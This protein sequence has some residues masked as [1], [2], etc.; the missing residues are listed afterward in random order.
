[1]IINAQVIHEKDFFGGPYVPEFIFNKYGPLKLATW[2]SLFLECSCIFL[3]WSRNKY[4]KYGTVYSMIALHLGIESTMNMHVFEILSIIGWC[5]FLIQPDISHRDYKSMTAKTNTDLNRKTMTRY[6]LDIIQ[7][8]WVVN[9]FLLAITTILILD[10]FPLYEIQDV[11]NGVI[12]V[13]LSSLLAKITSPSQ[14]SVVSGLVYAINHIETKLLYLNEL[15]R[16]YLFP[17]VTKY[18]YP[19]GLYQAVWTLYSGA[20]DMSCIFTTNITAYTIMP[21]S[22]SSNHQLN[23]YSYVSPD[24]GTMTWYEKKRYQR[25]MTMQEK[26][27]DYMYRD[28]YVRY[29]TNNIFNDVLSNEEAN[30]TNLHLA[31]ATL[32]VQCEHPPPAPDIDDWFNWSG[33]FYADAKQD[34]LVQREP[35]LLYTTN[36]CNDLNVELC[37]QYNNEGL[38]YIAQSHHSVRHRFDATNIDVLKEKEALVYNITQTCR[39]SCNFCPEDGYDTNDLSIGTRIS[40]YWPIPTW[41]DTDQ[42]YYYDEKSLYYPGTIVQVR[43]HPLKQ[44]RIKYDESGYNDEWFD[45]MTL[46]DRGYHFVPPLDN[47]IIDQSA[48]APDESL[49]AEVVETQENVDDDAVGADNDDDEISSDDDD[50]VYSEESKEH[51]DE[52]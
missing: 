4:I 6:L 43:D 40:V 25:P 12:S 13:P 1:M 33:W 9:S 2:S 27:T 31:S 15:R 16:N 17:Y 10:T 36:I 21:D 35:R 26:L 37:Q 29:H 48:S 8:T 38:C 11:L 30:M 23:S 19:I 14:L 46:R 47:E 18:L 32:M 44:Y 51:G 49:E 22:N 50:D 42:K 52:L 34:V 41:D 20:P 7:H 3:V 5:M 28:G 45:P 39:R 24:W